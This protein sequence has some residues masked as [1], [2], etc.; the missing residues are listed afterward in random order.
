MSLLSRT[1][2]LLSEALLPTPEVYRLRVKS[3]GE[4]LR[5]QILTV[6]GIVS[7]MRGTVGEG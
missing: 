2:C 3:V 5:I 7:K 1:V 4:K 6:A